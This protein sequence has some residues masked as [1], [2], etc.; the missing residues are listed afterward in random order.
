MGEIEEHLSAVITAEEEAEASEP[1]ARA[2]SE[3]EDPALEEEAGPDACRRIADGDEELLEPEEPHARGGDQLVEIR[4]ILGV[5]LW[6]ERVSRPRP[7][8]F[9]VAP[10]FLPA[11]EATV[12]QLRERVPGSFGSL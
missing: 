6:Y 11:V 10:A 9:N 1:R 2:D 3:P 4:E 5:P 8:R 7:S 12:R